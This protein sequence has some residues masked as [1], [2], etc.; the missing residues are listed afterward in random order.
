MTSRRPSSAGCSPRWSR[1]HDDGAV[2]LDGAAADRRPPRRPRPRRRRR[3]RH[4][5]GVADHERRRGRRR[6]CAPS[7]TRSATAPRSSPGVGTN[8]TAHSRRAGRAGRRSSAPTA[9]LLVT[10][11]YNKPAQAGVLAPLHAPVADATDLPVMLYDVPGRT[12]TPIA[13]RDAARGSP[14]TRGRRGQGRRRRPVR[15]AS[16]SWPDWATPSTPATTCSTSRWLAHGAAGVVSRRRPR[17]PATQYAAHGR[18][19]PRRRPRR[20]PARST[21]GCCPRSTPIMGVTT[22]APSPPRQRSQLLGVLDN[23]NVRLPLVPPT[24]DEVAA[25]RA[26]LADGSGL[27]EDTTHEPPA[28]RARPHRPRCPQGGLRV[29]PLGGL[30]EV[31]RNMTVFEYDGRL[32]IVDCGVLFPE[33]HHPGVDLILPDFDAIR[34]RLDDVEALVLTHG[35]EDHIGAMP[36]LLRER[37]DIPLVGSRADPGAA[38]G[39]AAASTGS[40]RPSTTSVKEGDRI[41]FGALR[42]RVRRGQ[43]LD[44]RRARGRD[45]HRRRHWCC[46][47]ATSRWT[48]CRS[49]AGSPTCARSPGSARRASTCS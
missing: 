46:T 19:R 44:P 5:R 2:D 38:R 3:Q 8:A 29:I 37:G 28:P 26:G 39:Q 36:Y 45:P 13:H 18:R 32:L 42:P 47:P 31:G 21:R 15:A 6:S 7:W 34:D 4:D 30:G 49:T 10:P 33:E 25:L 9:L 1:L 16:R 40:R 22:T 12:G 14:S 48:S 17:R 27:L 20:A 43:P 24:D 35:H 41:A 11:Y 23:R